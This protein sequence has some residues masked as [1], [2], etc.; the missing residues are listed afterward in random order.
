[1]DT[2][3]ASGVILVVDLPHEAVLAQQFVRRM[4]EVWKRV[5]RAANTRGQLTLGRTTRTQITTTKYRN[6]HKQTICAI[7][8][9]FTF[10]F[11][12]DSMLS[13]VEAV[14]SFGPMCSPEITERLQK[15]L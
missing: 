2:F 5:R 13:S 14:I 10:T 12:E 4:L 11:G 3:K 8:H 6:I 9:T 15:S 1:M 7:I